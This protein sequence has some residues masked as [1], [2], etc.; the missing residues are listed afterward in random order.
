MI[1]ARPDDV[2]AALRDVGAPHE[3]LAPGPSRDP[4][5]PGATVDLVL[6]RSA[7]FPGNL[8]AEPS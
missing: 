4:V 5:E 1:E 8:G 7:D 6:F 2:W 3:R